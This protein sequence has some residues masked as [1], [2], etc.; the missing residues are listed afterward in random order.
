MTDGAVRL[1]AFLRKN[2]ITQLSAA[3]S[4][5]VSDP[6]VHDWVTGSKRPRA[7]HRDAIAT[8]THGEVG[9]ESWLTAEEQASRQAVRPFES[10]D[11]SGEHRALDKSDT[12]A[13]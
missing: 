7:H 2:G 8:W 9:T 12:D 3:E 11:D 6:T 4:L 10:A 13:A 1:A 5:G